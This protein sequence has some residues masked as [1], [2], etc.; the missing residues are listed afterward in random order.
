[1]QTDQM[2]SFGPYRLD[3][4]AARLWRGKQEVRLTG[5]AF[6]VLRHLLTH[7]GELVTKDELFQAV[8]PGTVVS[9][10]ALTSCIKE[11]R[12]VLHDTAQERRYIETV[13]RRGFRFIG[14]LRAFQGHTTMPPE[15]GPRDAGGG[16]EVERKLAAILSADVQGYSRLMGEDEVAT[17]RTLTAYREVITILIHHHHGR[18]VD[19]PGDNLLAEFASAVD[20]VQCAVEIQQA[21]AAKNA[22]LPAKRQ[23]AFRIGLNVGDV[24]VEGSQLYGDG[25]NIAARLEGLAEAGGLCISGTVYDQIK[26]KVALTYEPLGERVV[27]NIAEPVRAYRVKWEPEGRAAPSPATPAQQGLP[28]SSFKFQVPSSQ[29]ALRTPHSA[30]TLV[31][32][33]SELRQLHEWLEKALYGERQI[34]FVAGEPGIGKTT[35]VDAFL[36]RLADEHAHEHDLWLGR[37]QCIE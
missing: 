37:G 25:V 17:V 26:N 34:V 11:L 30:I 2:L 6:A 21:L 24:V 31:G 14:Q 36:A 29:S 1:M 33:E 12:Q 19:A 4:A 20:A 35:L 22:D 16:R 28:V 32:R 27:K 15:T 5:K 18:V 3:L 23:M 8:W 7:A 13:H 9:E 10:A